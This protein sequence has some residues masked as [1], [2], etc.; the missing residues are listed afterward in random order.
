MK[1]RPFKMSQINKEKNVGLA[2]VNKLL[3]K[4]I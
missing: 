2:Y 4:G 1:N 3:M